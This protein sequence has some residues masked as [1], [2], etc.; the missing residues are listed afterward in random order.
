MSRYLAQFRRLGSIEF[1]NDPPAW[2][3]QAHAEM[4]VSRVVQR[5]GTYAT[6]RVFDNLHR[7]IVFSYDRITGERNLENG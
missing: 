5:C 3:E 7:K 1:S 6:G 2:N 4:Y